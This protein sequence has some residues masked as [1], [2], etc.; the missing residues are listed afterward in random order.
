MKVEVEVE[1]CFHSFFNYV[2]EVGGQLHV[3]AVSPPGKAL[4]IHIRQEAG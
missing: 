4:T 3:L 1:V 2:I